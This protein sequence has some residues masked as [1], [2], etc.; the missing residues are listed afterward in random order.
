MNSF[1]DLETVLM[2]PIIKIIIKRQ[3]LMKS[4][5]FLGAMLVFP[6]KISKS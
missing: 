1:F 3:K 4:K 5:I 2:T 6:K